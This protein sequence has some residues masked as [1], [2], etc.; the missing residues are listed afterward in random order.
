METLIYICANR[1]PKGHGRGSCAAKGAEAIISHLRARLG[2]MG[3]TQ[4]QVVRSGCMDRCA[5]GPGAL[6]YTTGAW[7]RL[8]DEAAVDALVDQFFRQT[9]QRQ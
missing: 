2:A 1:R 4:V 3:L 6:F 5:L 9:G 8:E 7:R